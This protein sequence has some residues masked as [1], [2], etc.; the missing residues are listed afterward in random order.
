MKS[1]LSIAVHHFNYN[2]DRSSK[3]AL[4]LRQVARSR[5]AWFGLVVVGVILA[6]APTASAQC[7][8][9]ISAHE[10]VTFAETGGV[11]SV[12][13]TA[14][15]GCAW[16]AS[17][18]APWIIIVPP[19]KG[20]GNGTVVYSLGPNTDPV[21]L[22]G[23][24][25]VA[26]QN[27]VI[28]Q[29]GNNCATIGQTSSTIS[30]A[31]GTGSV[32]VTAP[33]ACVWTATSNA[34]WINITSGFSGTGNGVITYFVAA[35]SGTESRTGTITI[36]GKT[37]TVTQSPGL[38]S[39]GPGG[40]RCTESFDHPGQSFRA[41]GG[42]DSIVIFT[43]DKCWWSVNK[44]AD[45]ITITSPTS[46][47]ASG[48][49]VLVTYSVAPNPGGLSRTGKIVTTLGLIFTVSQAAGSGNCQDYGIAGPTGQEFPSSGGTGTANVVSSQ[50][51]A[52]TVKSDVPWI[53]VTSGQGVGNGVIQFSVS[54]SNEPGHRIGH[55][56]WG[57]GSTALGVVEGGITCNISTT[58]SKGTYFQFAYK[59]GNRTISV[60]LPQICSWTATTDAAWISITSGN[61]GSGSG[62][63]S[64]SVAAN[65]DPNTRSANVIVTVTNPG[66]INDKMS[67]FVSQAC[68]CARIGVTPSVL[69][70]NIP[71][72]GG[73]NPAPQTLQVKNVGAGTL[74]WQ[75]RISGG[76]E[77][78]QS[79]LAIDT[80]SGTAPSSATVTI[81]AAGLRQGIY[82][83][84][85]AI[86]ASAG[87]NAIQN[88]F[89]IP[90][91]VVV[92]P[93]TDNQH[94]FAI[95][96]NGGVSLQSTGVGSSSVGYG[97]I[98]GDAFCCS[99]PP[100][101]AI[102]DFVL[103]NILVSETGVPAVPQTTEGRLYVE[104]SKTA[105]TS[106]NTGIAIANLN[107]APAN[108]SF[109][110]TDQNGN[111]AG[112][113]TTQIPPN[114]QLARFLSESPFK[115]YAGDSFGGSFSFTSDVPVAV[116][117]LRGLTNERGEFLMS[118]VP[119]V[120]TAIDPGTSPV[121]VPHFADGG[122][123]TTQILLVNPTDS[124]VSGD[125][126]FV[127]SSGSAATVTVSGQA[128]NTFPFSIPPR[129]A[130]KIATDGT[131]TS[132]IHGSVRVIP[133]AGSV[134][135][136][137]LVVFSERTRGVTVAE[138]G[139]PVRNGSRFRMYVE[140]DAAMDSGIAVANTSAAQMPVTFELTD[141]NGLPVDGADPTA[142]QIPASGQVA[143]LLSE[144]FPSLQKPF[145]GVLRISASTPVSIAG[146]RQ[147]INE[148]GEYL[149]TTIQV[150]NEANP[151]PNLPLVF[152]HVVNGGGFTTQF[153]LFSG[154]AN[155]VTAG[156]LNFVKQDGTPLSLDVN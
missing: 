139:V 110:F 142:L 43:Q 150:R 105:T 112:S 152:P 69:Q 68:G 70:F 58:S 102:F 117:A 120:N 104:I 153:V 16:T 47:N 61:T 26:G 51:C 129:G 94:L 98:R 140:A 48:T 25:T 107:N 96:D 145:K 67:F 83:G 21:F 29:L 87:S 89:D 12:D 126:K 111:P 41:D 66:F 97:V 130:Q 24:I 121:I 113:G 22:I 99:T 7:T 119:V 75:S 28:N 56:I 52:W 74:S 76:T 156:V 5:P 60:A 62:T 57:N 137:A 64:F 15:P 44:D 90:V 50:G 37:F 53:T 135:P 31:G 122:G 125:V 14:P 49:S 103:N 106:L 141:L 136:E 149:I 55:L 65:S 8:Y 73:P 45:W 108:I 4:V 154:A 18:N 93:P 128:G 92:G 88:E 118:T 116:I 13:V 131:G 95:P 146:L 42:T 144:L 27:V 3:E 109:Y 36:L 85:I 35:H 30:A 143:V 34:S 38:A 151:A 127:D 100:G 134:T 11:G 155:Q 78:R 81:N 6:A 101:V 147:R 23:S 32:S 33:A 63:V 124:A 80:T 59:G 79:W 10:P 19:S 39:G 40:D 123:W 133:T 54:P 91:Q 9:S 77:N 46:G 84:T 20:T 71:H 86:V 115:V 132:T 1:P 2:D 17:S 114:Q 82:D 138:A 148:R 72:A